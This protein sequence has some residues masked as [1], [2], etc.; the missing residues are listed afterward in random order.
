M[1]VRIRRTGEIVCAATHPAEE[2]DTYLH[3]GIS[4]RLSVELHA[5]VTDRFHLIAEDGKSPGHGKWWWANDVPE[6]IE[7]DRWWD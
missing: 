6:G 3:D 2:G 5:L 1:A 7:V 4:Y